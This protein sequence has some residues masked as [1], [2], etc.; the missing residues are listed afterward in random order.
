MRRFAQSKKGHSRRKCEAAERRKTREWTQGI[1]DMVGLEEKL[2][3]VL[4]GI[5][6][7]D[8]GDRCLD[9]YLEGDDVDFAQHPLDHRIFAWR[10]KDQKRVVTAIGDDPN[11]VLRCAASGAPG[12][13]GQRLRGG[14]RSLRWWRRNTA[15]EPA[16]P[17]PRAAPQASRSPPSPP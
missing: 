1:C 2:G 15:G 4:K 5:I 8:L 16:G 10:G 9:Q 14:R 7:V 3:A 6:Q 17:S 13:G 11:T 12:F